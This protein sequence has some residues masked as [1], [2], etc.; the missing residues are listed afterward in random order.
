HLGLAVIRRH[1]ALVHRAILAGVSGPDHELLTLPSTIQAQ[2]EKIDRLFKA[3][4]E[5]NRLIPDFLGLVRRL[6]RQLEQKPVTVALIEP[7]T[8]QPAS[9]TVGRWDLQFFASARVQQTWGIKSLPA[10]FYP[11]SQGDFRPLAEAALAF[12]RGE[13]GN[14][15]PHLVVCASGVSPARYR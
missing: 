1:P 10:F 13:I 5:V 6:L 7:Q 12:R 14:V 9:V 4:P 15:M 3:D 2:L 11:M 8:H